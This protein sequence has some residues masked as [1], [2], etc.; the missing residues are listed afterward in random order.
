VPSSILTL[1][2]L[3][4]T[5]IHASRCLELH[6]SVRFRRLEVH[7]PD[8]ERKVIQMGP[9]CG[10][11]GSTMLSVQWQ[12]SPTGVSVMS[13]LTNLRSCSLAHPTRSSRPKVESC[14]S[15]FCRLEFFCLVTRPPSQP[16]PQIS[17]TTQPL[18]GPRLSWKSHRPSYERRQ[19]C[20]LDAYST[21]RHV[22]SLTANKL[23][24]TALATQSERNGLQRKKGEVWER[25][26]THVAA[27][28][29]HVV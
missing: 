6:R 18:S 24:L 8:Q 27:N 25:L 29:R 10:H 9:S 23:N 3:T 5:S 4:S 26:V 20:W 2:S 1:C 16:E 11:A 17:V 7:Y 13:G 15:M 14:V 21:H 22:K 12:R 19:G 28:A